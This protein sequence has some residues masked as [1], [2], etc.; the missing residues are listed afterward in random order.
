M[1]QH[2][3]R[4]RAAVSSDDFIGDRDVTDMKR[5]DMKLVIV[6][7]PYAGVTQIDI[8]RNVAYA[9]AAVRD[10]VFRGEAPL[11]S[12]LLFTQPNILR[13]G[14]EEERELGIK[15]GIAWRRVVRYGRL[16]Y[17]SWIFQRHAVGARTL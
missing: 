11:A 13:D 4:R 1:D 15:A 16:L 2:F 14:V 8:Q 5:E 6:E 9:R 17:R 7:S 12:H 3:R 10:S